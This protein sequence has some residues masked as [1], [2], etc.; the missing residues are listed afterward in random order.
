MIAAGLAANTA[1][2]L[3]QRLQGKPHDA[4]HAGTVQ[5]GAV[6]RFGAQIDSLLP[7][8]GVAGKAV[9]ALGSLGQELLN[10]LGL[11]ADAAPPPAAQPRA[12]ARAYAATAGLR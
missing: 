2:A 9:G 7:G 3:L 10:K 11:G 4:H 1:A 8:A 5:A 6:E 12:A